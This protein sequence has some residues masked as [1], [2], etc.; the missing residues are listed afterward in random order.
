MHEAFYTLYYLFHEFCLYTIFREEFHD[1]LKIFVVIN[2]IDQTVSCLWDSYNPFR[3]ST[4]VVDFAAHFTRYEVIGLSVEED[5]WNIAGF[6]GVKRSI[7]F[8]I[9]MTEEFCSQFDEW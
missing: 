8:Q 6:H 2:E 7:F 1:I 5:D 4:G 3:R 9:K